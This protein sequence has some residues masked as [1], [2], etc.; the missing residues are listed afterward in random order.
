MIRLGAALEAGMS[1]KITKSWFAGISAGYEW[2]DD[3]SMDIGPNTVTLDLSGFS[4][5]ATI[6]VKF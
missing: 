3:T 2:I 5:S 1:F 4:T 6:G